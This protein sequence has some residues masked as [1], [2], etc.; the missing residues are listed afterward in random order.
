ML[1]VALSGLAAVALAAAPVEQVKLNAPATDAVMLVARHAGLNV[2]AAPMTGLVKGDYAA[3]PREAFARQVLEK[4]PA[5]VSRRENFVFV[6]KEPPS[7]GLPRVAELGEGGNVPFLWEREITAGQL[8]RTLSLTLRRPVLVASPHDQEVITAV[9]QNV[10]VTDAIAA[11]AFYLGQPVTLTSEGFVSIG[12]PAGAVSRDCAG[13]SVSE[14]TRLSGFM[15]G[16]YTTGLLQT[17]GVSCA[18][19]TGRN[20]RTSDGEVLRTLGADEGAMVYR[21]LAGAKAGS[22]VR[23]GFDGLTEI[24]PCEDITRDSKLKRTNDNRT[25]ALLTQGLIECGVARNTKAGEFE[26][27]DVDA[28]GPY[29]KNSST[30]AS[31]APIIQVTSTGIAA[32]SLPVVGR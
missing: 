14:W 15:P 19:E 32:G 6:G 10:K 2:L 22:Y 3:T 18:T 28:S 1:T 23:I 9:L 27:L 30:S 11:L 13:F 21:R 8:A 31:K 4:L 25:F 24:R 17:G 16:A 5:K 7:K 20:V 29:I 26:I 12:D